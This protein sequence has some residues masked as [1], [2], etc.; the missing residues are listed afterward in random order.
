VNGTITDITRPLSQTTPV[1]PGDEPLSVGWTKPHGDD[2]AAV[3]CLR[4]SPHVGTHLDAPL[5]LDPTGDDVAS[6]PLGVC[7]GRCEVVAVSGHLR[8]I[9]RGDLPARWVPSTPRVLFATSTWPSGAAI[10]PSF[11]SLS[12]GLVDFLA[13]AGVVLVGLDTPSV[14]DPSAVGLPAHRRCMARGIAILEGL[15]LSGAV[16][17][18]STLVAAPLRLEGVEASPVRAFLVGESARP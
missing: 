10:P 6:V 11:A 13:G 14:D 3:S 18:F 16:P 12:L 8:P 1:W 2:R 17:G 9:L 5:H 7:V 4:F 15:D